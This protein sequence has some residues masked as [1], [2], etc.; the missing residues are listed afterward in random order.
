MK[1]GK[2]CVLF[3]SLLPLV[4][5]EAGLFDIFDVFFDKDDLRPFD[6]TDLEKD[7]RESLY[8]QH[9]ALEAILKAVSLFMRDPEPSKPLVLSFHGPTGVGKSFVSKIIA[10]NIFKKGE[11]SS[12]VHLIISDYHFPH[13]S[14]AALY[15]T[16]LREWIYG[17][18]S[19]FPRSMFIFDE[20]DKMNPHLI[21][22]IK[23]FLDYSDVDKVSF[24]NAIFIF[25]SHAPANLIINMTLDFWKEGKER[26]EIN[27]QELEAQIYQNILNEKD[28]GFWQSS[29]LG[30]HLVDHFIAFLP[31][32]LKH[33]RQCVLAEMAN[34]NMTED[35]DLADKVAKDMSFI[36]PDNIFAVKG[37]KS[38]RYK[39]GQHMKLN[40]TEL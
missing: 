15:Q 13:K 6:Y 32:E 23:P 37:C 14:E 16:Q 7:L 8:G 33:V 24:R 9:I 36:P 2:L 29:L 27:G 28:N 40:K 17:N 18:V 38:I 1:S 4:T 5:V 22:A 11:K 12:H 25:L 26:V 19:S 35:F 21:D 34:L 10:R 39:L 31:L 20:M 3:F 30:Q